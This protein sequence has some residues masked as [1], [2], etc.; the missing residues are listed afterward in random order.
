[1]NVLITGGA[2]YIGSTIANY[3]LD[4]KCIVTVVDN[5]ATGKIENIP[6]GCI[7][8]KC[9]IADKKKISHILKKKFDLVIHFAAYIKVDESILKPK[10]YINNNYLKSKIFIN[11]CIKN[12]IKNL[13]VSSTAAVYKSSNK[14]VTENS[15]LYPLSPYSKSKLNLEKF[16]FRK[17]KINFII[18]RYF[19]VGGVERK[20]R[21]GFDIKNKSLISNLLNSLI[22]K[23]N[24]FIYGNQ[25]STKDGT[26]IRDFI[27]VND[28]AYIHY[29]FAKKILKKKYNKIF[30][31]GYGKPMTVLDIYNIFCKA[32]NKFPQIIYK[33]NKKNDIGISISDISRLKREI[34]IKYSKKKIDDLA[35]SSIKWFLKKSN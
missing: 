7:F 24:F 12:K 30:N 35:K 19:N 2:G 3:L 15:I 18:L 32:Y 21:S 13:I 23:K 5:L 8:F 22:K 29:K 34:S 27:H 31:C 9:D 17:N 28:L 11:L 4:K 1:M 26:A 14:K 20:M 16:L 10:K 25:Y 33:K 6:M